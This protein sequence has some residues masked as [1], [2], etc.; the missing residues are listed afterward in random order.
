MNLQLGI[1]ILFASMFS[2]TQAQEIQTHKSAYSPEETSAKL[3]ELLLS[4]SFSIISSINH[5]DAAEKNDIILGYNEL[6]I[7]GDPQV[8]SL[9][10]QADPRIGVDLPLKILIWEKDS[11]T[12]ISYK[13]PELFLKLYKIEQQKQIIDKMQGALEEIMETLKTEN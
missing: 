6:L 13:N 7:F 3:K 11:K 1:A 8:G 10:M 2:F 5:S 4:N 12:F 9:L